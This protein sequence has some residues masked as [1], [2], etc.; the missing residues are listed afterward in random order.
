MKVKCVW[1]EYNTRNKAKAIEEDVAP[2]IAKLENV[3]KIEFIDQN[4]SRGI[5]VC[6]FYK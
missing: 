2:V 1:V 3:E 4:S 5:C 6:I